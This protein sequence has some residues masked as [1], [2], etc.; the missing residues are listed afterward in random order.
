MPTVLGTYTDF[1]LKGFK[2]KILK[3]L[4]VIKEFAP[5]IM[6]GKDLY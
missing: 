1:L 4:F 3:I 6:M 2:K 5:K